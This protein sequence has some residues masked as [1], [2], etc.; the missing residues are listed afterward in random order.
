MWGGANVI[1]HLMITQPT[2]IWEMAMNDSTC[3]DKVEGWLD[4]TNGNAIRDS[5]M[6]AFPKLQS[7]Q[8]KMQGGAK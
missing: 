2:H 5:E 7:G 6:G 8:V 1:N 4:Q 3:I